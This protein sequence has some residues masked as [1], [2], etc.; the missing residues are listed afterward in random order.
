MSVSAS[1]AL[2][3]TV[4]LCRRHPVAVLAIALGLAAISVGLTLTRLTFETSELHLLPPGQGYVT[5]YREYSKAFGEL[6][7]LVIVTQG[8]TWQESRA[9]AARLAGALHAGP[10]AFNHLAYRVAPEDFAG[11]ALLYLPT[12]ALTQ[13]REDVYEHQDFIESFAAEPGLVTLLDGVNRRLAGA[14]VTHFLDLGLDDGAGAADVRFLT[15]L[16]TQ[17]R[18]AIT[19]PGVSATPWGSMLPLADGEEDT[20]YFLSDDK[21]LLYL[22]ADPVGGSGGFTNDGAALDE[23]RLQITRLRAEFPGVEAGVTG[24]PALA[25]DG[26]RAA[27]ADSRLATGL[28]FAL[29][30]GL[31]LLAFRRLRDPVVMLAVLALSLTWSLGLVTLTVGHLTVFSVMFISIVIGLG[32]DYGIYV[33]FRFDEERRRGAGAGE[34][35]ER[36]AARSGPGILLGALTG[37]ATFYVLLVTDFHGVQEL[38]FI[39]GTALLAAFVAMLTVF[40]ALLAL[41][42]GGRDGAPGSAPKA[43]SAAAVTVPFVERLTRHPVAVLALAGAL[44][45]FALWSARTLEFDYDLLDLQARGTESVVWERRITQA[46][47][48]SSYAALSTATSLAE[49]ERKRAAFERLPSVAGVESALMFIPD[50]QAAK[51]K[52]VRDVAAVIAPL[53]VGSTPALDVGRVGSALQVL[54]RRLD[55]AADMAG[56]EGAGELGTLRGRLADLLRAVEEAGQVRAKAGWARYQADLGRDFADKLRFLRRNLDPRLVTFADIPATIR[57]KFISD[58]GQFLLQVQ[59]KVDVWSREGAIRF[60]TDLRSVDADVTG[61][62]VITFE[63][64]RRMDDAW[65]RGGALA[66]LVVGVISGL[67]LR[68]LRETALALVPLVL[69]TLWAIGLLPL[70]GLKLNVANVWGVPLIIG[71]SA[72]YGLN[73]ITRALE[74]RAH[75][76]PRFA[77]STILAV[78][79]NGLTTISGFGTL[80]LA[81]HRGMWSLGLL[82]TLGSVTSLVASIMVLPVLMRLLDPAPEAGGRV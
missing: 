10:I 66:V 46:H 50:D 76:G 72:E 4:V 44:T 74:A 45:A 52:I 20:G 36:T 7:E 49:L 75:G 8:R 12:P 18:D 41:L 80:M 19:R 21:R 79:F 31:L 63:S 53:R 54:R 37:T 16:L 56:P 22:L 81:H 57:R 9:F 60:V 61:T 55:V 5:R 64:I 32:I 29:T 27:F 38:G 17:M 67:M 39:A 70:F 25:T 35:L 51:A 2:R 82:L 28:A 65:R 47:G 15:T 1:R 30:L 78:V 69:G 24:G 40:P 58:G 59:P 11:R 33:L 77:R 71:A 14:F 34:A 42:H 6:D 62:P 23:I 68:R 48:R 43:V 13:L 3:R 26:M 73:V